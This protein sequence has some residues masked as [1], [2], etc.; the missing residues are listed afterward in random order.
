MANS[1][2]AIVNSALWAAA[3]DALGWMTELGDAAALQARADLLHVTEPAP[4]R[5]I[6]GG[7]FGVR[8]RLPVGTYSDDT[9]LRLAV[10]RS[11][12]RD[13]MFDV[14][15][16]ASIE[17]PVWLGYALGAGHG[18]A[19]A[20]ANLARQGTFWFSNFYDG[21][22]QS[23]IGAGGNGAA[24]RVQPHVWAASA[25]ARN[26][27]AFLLPLLKDALTTH[28]HRHGFCGAVFHALTL[29]DAIERGTVPGPA[30]WRGYAEA[31]LDIPKIIAGEPALQGSWQ[32]LWERMTG[33]ALHSAVEATANELVQ[34]L[35]DLTSIATYADGLRHLGCFDDRFRGSGLKT[36]IAASM[37]A[38]LFRD[39][40]LEEALQTAANAFGSDTDTIGTMAGAILGATTAEPPTWSVQDRGYI[41]SQAR[42]L[43]KLGRGISGEAFT[44]PSLTTWTPPRESSDIVRKAGN[45]LIVLGLGRARP[46]GEEHL[47]GDVTWQWLEL[48]IGQTIFAPRRKP[49]R[50]E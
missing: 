23:Y 33:Q 2:V 42:R 32:P 47:A 36:A 39:R 38:W 19:T 49:P 20:A 25:S 16:F 50:P 22:L 30:D 37:L 15:A 4:W 27:K 6:V 1:E 24:M 21:R 46:R 7:R 26:R 12:G 40:S 29:S 43:A 14:Q 45:G 35:S 8:V 17:L 9:Q 10:G 11:I 44:Y 34:D 13:G 48:A 5:H 41:E 3:G 18:T 31:F 28:G